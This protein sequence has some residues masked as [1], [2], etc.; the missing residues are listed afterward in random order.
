[1]ANWQ[2]H[3]QIDFHDRGM[4]RHYSPLITA[5]TNVRG[6][7][8]CKHRRKHVVP[9]DESYLIGISGDI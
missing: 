5:P 1:M 2:C 4:G 7:Y 3:N 9:Y 8:I 6:F